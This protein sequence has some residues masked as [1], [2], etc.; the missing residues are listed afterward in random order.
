[1]S[2]PDGT[3]KLGR[4]WKKELANRAGLSQALMT[5]MSQAAAYSG[6]TGFKR[7]TMQRLCALEDE[8][9]LGILGFKYE[10]TPT[11]AASSPPNQRWVMRFVHAGSQDDYVDLCIEYD[12]VVLNEQRELARKRAEAKE[13]RHLEA[14][15]RWRADEAAY[16]FQPHKARNLPKV[17][18]VPMHHSEVDAI[19]SLFQSLTSSAKTSKTTIVHAFPHSGIAHALQRILPTCEGFQ[20]YYQGGVH[21]LHIGALEYPHDARARL[22][23]QLL[24]RSNE[25]EERYR[26]MPVEKKIAIQM[27]RLNQLLIIHGSSAIPDQA[28]GFIRRL[29]DELEETSGLQ[30]RKGVSRLILTSWEPGAFS[31]LN[32]RSPISF[33]YRASV[34]PEEAFEYFNVALEHYRGIRGTGTQRIGRAGPRAENSILKR[35][36]HHY[37]GKSSSFTEVPSAVRFRA[38]CASDT[39]NPSPFDPTQGVW[40]RVDPAWKKS[41]P[42]I[43]DCL[44]DIQSDLR[45]FSSMDVRGDLPA[46]RVVSTG[47]FFLTERMLLLLKNH[48]ISELTT[49]SIE[50][51]NHLQRKYVNFD[52]CDGEELSGKYSAPLLVRSIIQD[53]WMRFDPPSRSKIHEAIAEILRDM[54]DG[55]GHAEPHEE[56]PYEYPWGDSEVVLALE[57]IRHFARAAEGAPKYRAIEIIRKALDT[58]DDFLEQG[59]F[60][61]TDIEANRQA[62]GRLSRSHGLHALKYE[63]LCLLSAD[64]RGV[65]APIGTNEQEQYAFFREFG[66][67]LARMLRPHD[68]IAAFEKCLELDVLTKFDRAYVLAH[69]VSAG[70]LCGDPKRAGTFLDDARV[71]ESLENDGKLREKIKH[72]NDARAATLALARGRRRESRTR[73][74]A[75]AEEGITPY[76]GDRSIGYFDA[77]LAS[78]ITLKRDRTLAG[79]LWASIERASHVAHDQGFEHERL[80]IDIR[81]ASFARILGFPM[82]AEAI[83]DH[84]GLDLAKHS[85]AEILFREFQ[86]ESAETL[87]SLERPR[88]AFVA[89]AWPAFQSLRRRSTIPFLRRSRNLCARLLRD[90]SVVQDE[91]PPATGT[92]RFWSAIGRTSNGSLYPLFSVDLLPSRE[93]VESYFVELADPEMRRPYVSI[94]RE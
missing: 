2:C 18:Q 35:V 28:M 13:Q 5:K 38:F 78:P 9:F 55:E 47:L 29:S 3:S 6:T 60:S 90:M 88:Y 61:G 84:V 31:Y 37:R 65:R 56:I 34:S 39:M 91:P 81:K 11:S 12:V 27:H 20:N 58:Y 87:K 59:T 64:G 16:W 70:I 94:L 75:I 22:S 45:N 25:E 62:A 30:I 63:A 51:T 48:L 82:A 14:T 53:D 86:I 79:K 4:P 21:H 52:P 26:H 7:E 17:D 1:M 44:I 71:L 68:A 80:R 41:I 19:H 23:K 36:E 33:A 89:Y 32:K 15:A 74:E 40:N 66:I 57:A 10:A 46:L 76:Y 83:L 54:V 69:A 85:G 42:E 67:T 43:S 92:N 50:I 72:R 77:H 24:N 8:A 49:R 73:W 93:D